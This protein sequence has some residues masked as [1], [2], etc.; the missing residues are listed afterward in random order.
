MRR[1]CPTQQWQRR[2]S[3]TP[4]KPCN[5]HDQQLCECAVMPHVWHRLLHAGLPEEV[6]HTKQ[7][8]ARGYAVL[9]IDSK[10]R[11]F[12]NRCFRCGAWAVDCADRCQLVCSS[13]SSGRRCR[14][15]SRPIGEYEAAAPTLPPHRPWLPFLACSYGEDKWGFKYI[16]ENWTREK[17]GTS[18][19]R[20]LRRVVGATAHAGAAAPT[21]RDRPV[22]TGDKALPQR[23]PRVVALQGLDKLPIFA[24]GVSAGASFVLKLP[25]ITRINGIISGAALQCSTLGTMRRSSWMAGWP[26]CVCAV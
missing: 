6:A 5:M 17:V 24:L 7:A 22:C 16:L 19:R 18:G 11:D 13:D 3:L 9:A 15:S 14:R 4:Q 10:N 26:A 21:G 20:S 8:L 23:P 1:G 2:G 25:K 12:N